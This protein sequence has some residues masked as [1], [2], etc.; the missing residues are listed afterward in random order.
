[1]IKNVFIYKGYI[2]HRRFSPFNQKFNYKT[3]MC[4]FDISKIETMFKKSIFWNINKW[5]LVSFYRKDYHGDVNLSLDEAVRKTIKEKTD[6][7]P[8]GPIR[9]L[10]HLRYFG[11]CFNPVSFYYCFDKN[12]QEVEMI[13]AEVTNT[14]WNER[15][16]YFITDKKHKNFNQSLKKEFHVSPFWDMKHDYEWYFSI[17]KDSINVNMINYKK[18]KKVFDATLTLTEKSVLTFNNLLL[19]SLRFPFITLMVFFRIHFQALKLWIKGATFYDHPKYKE[20]N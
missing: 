7:N 16:C 14:P 10:T 3:F 8:E 2:R 13:M 4:Y 18:Q 17:P 15:H 5:A 12:D 19:H 11:Y 6:H 20:N 9:L 1:M